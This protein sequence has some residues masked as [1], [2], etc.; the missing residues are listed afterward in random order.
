MYYQAIVKHFAAYSPLGTSPKE[1]YDLGRLDEIIEETAYH[2]RI[3]YLSFE[4]T[5]P[6]DGSVEVSIE[7][8]KRASFDF[9]CS[10]SDSIDIDGYDLLTSLGSNL[11]FTEQCASISNYDAIEIV[12]QNFGFDLAGGITCVPLDMNE[13]H[14][15]LEIRGITVTNTGGLR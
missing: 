11:V 7:Q 8:F 3:F 13:P 4:I 9:H 10:G 14:Y 12:R 6:A 2:S 5:V 1:R 15:Y